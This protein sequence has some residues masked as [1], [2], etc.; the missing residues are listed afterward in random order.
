LLYYQQNINQLSELMSIQ[1]ISEYSRKFIHSCEEST[2][3]TQTALKA[4]QVIERH[5]MLRKQYDSFQKRYDQCW[6]QLSQSDSP[7]CGEATQIHDQVEQSWIEFERNL[8]TTFPYAEIQHMKPLISE[9]K[10]SKKLAINPQIQK[11]YPSFR[12]V[13]GDG[14]CF[15]TSFALSYI[16]WLCQNQNQIDATLQR[17]TELPD[18]RGKIEVIQLIN[19]L[20]ENPSAWDSCIRSNTQLFIFISFLRHC[21]AFH[22]ENISTDWKAGY[23]PETAKDPQTADKYV[24]DYVLKMGSEAQHY[25]INA[26]TQFLRCQILLFDHRNGLT[27]FNE[28]T[29]P[30]TC[31]VY[32]FPHPENHYCCLQK[33]AAP[34]SSHSHTRDIGQDCGPGSSSA[35]ATRKTL[36][37]DQRS[38]PSQICKTA[39]IAIPAIIGLAAIVC[40]WKYRNILI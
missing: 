15:Y 40:S 20:K 9:L 7:S 16:Q 38:N 2:Q 11:D 3:L 17:V 34:A 8:L 35:P 26:L 39:Q 32:Y 27:Q 12:K 1:S 36:P 5:F 31:A 29:G 19:N 18:Y 28:G 21:A 13:L 23:W 24:Q 30:V 25:E 4:D 37:R 22:L 6:K 14:N 10:P 33:D